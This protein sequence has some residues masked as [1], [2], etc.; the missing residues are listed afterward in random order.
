MHAARCAVDWFAAFCI[1][2]GFWVYARRELECSGTSPERSGNVVERSAARLA[3]SAGFLERS[4]GGV[5]R[6]RGLFERSRDARE[7]SGVFAERSRSF[8]E[9]SRKLAERSNCC[10]VRSGVGAQG[11][12]TTFRPEYGMH[13]DRFGMFV[14][15]FGLG[16][17]VGGLLVRWWYCRAGVPGGGMAGAAFPGILPVLTFLFWVS[18]LAPDRFGGGV[19]FSRFR[20]GFS[21][22][23][24]ALPLLKGACYDSD[25]SPIAGIGTGD[26]VE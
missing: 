9:R 6:S 10:L 3:Y 22:S 14:T 7:R 25:V 23:F 26:V 1:G 12:G 11:T 17:K 19:P 20:P 13:R 16:D 4:R 8:A 18:V 5:E 15:I 21:I 24:S 2:N